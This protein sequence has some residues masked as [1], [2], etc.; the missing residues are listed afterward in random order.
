VAP[1]TLVPQVETILMSMCPPRIRPRASS[2]AWFRRAA[3]LRA[4][5]VAVGAALALLPAC[6]AAAPE[7]LRVSETWPD[8]P[9]V[10]TGPE[11][12]A[13]DIAHHVHSLADDA[14]AGR[15][16]G[17]NESIVAA[18]YL[19]AVLS[20]AGLR[21]AG[22]GGSFLQVTDTR[23]LTSGAAPLLQFLGD[24][25][26]TAAPG[27]LTTSGVVAVSGVDFSCRPGAPLLDTVPIVIARTAADVP[28]TPRADAALCLATGSRQARQW[29]DAAGTPDGR[30]WALLLLAGEEKPGAPDDGPVTAL[31]TAPVDGDLPPTRF[32][33][34]GPLRD[35]VVGG[36]FRHVRA[37]L[38]GV[39]VTPAVNV[40]G[41]I[42]GVGTPEHPELAQQAIV[43]TAHYD[44]LGVARSVQDV[45]RQDA[46]H[47]PDLIYNGADDDA[48][49]CAAVL[50]LAEAFG[51]EARAGRPLARTLVFL[52]VTGEEVGLIGTRYYLDHPVVPLDRTV[53]NLNFEMI[54]RPDALVGGAGRLWLTGFERSNLGP[55]WAAAGLAIAPD[56]R[57]QEHFFER[58]DNF[59][60]VMR[61][62]VGQTLST[63]DLH[64]DYHHVTDAPETLDYPH[65]EGAVRAGLAAARMLAD[66]S[67][68]PAW[69]GPPPGSPGG[70][71]SGS[72]APVPTPTPAPAGAPR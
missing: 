48:S 65:M 10:A 25:P 56:G 22:N 50:E 72:P 33:L 4:L 15:A 6:H 39:S 7:A 54:G 42:D 18:E 43:F 23:R 46:S 8:A 12:T 13:A 26:D 17:S 67:L 41:V 71:G 1:P 30:G 5:L 51:A 61:G 29:L 32:S 35:R 59:A 63:Y 34:R 62:I 64:D 69:I 68:N 36:E 57:P 49:G 38:R 37:V 52:L 2:A 28:K 60:F 3:A 31:V 55:A 11:V 24:V 40:V 21:G 14:M 16:T 47:A 66:G 53:C 19:A 45:S 27:A 70:P 9:A 58:S 44:H 20:A